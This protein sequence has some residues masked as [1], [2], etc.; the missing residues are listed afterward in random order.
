VVGAV[1]QVPGSRVAL[2][3]ALPNI[4]P[5]PNMLEELGVE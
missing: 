4:N 2:T 1:A 3:E 5:S